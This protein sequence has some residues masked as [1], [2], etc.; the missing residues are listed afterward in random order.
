ML[1]ERPSFFF[2]MIGGGGNA[3]WPPEFI[4]AIYLAL[5]NA[6]LDYDFGFC[7]ETGA[8]Y[9]LERGAGVL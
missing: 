4:A 2:S 6:T 5:F 8:D 1:N 9:N 3:L 7:P